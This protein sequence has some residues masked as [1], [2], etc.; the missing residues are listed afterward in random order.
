VLP[1]SGSGRS[2]VGLAVASLLALGL[3]FAMVSSGQGG[4]DSLLDN[5]LLTGP[6]VFVA[7][8]G[9]A[10]LMAGLLALL[11]SHERGLLVVLPILWGLVVTLFIVGEL[12]NP[13]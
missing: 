3:F 9:I 5:W 2:S 7:V 13:H 12:A 8:G 1:S 11:R 6:I 10:G 4:G